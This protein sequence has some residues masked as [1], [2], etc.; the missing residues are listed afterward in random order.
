MLGVS[1]VSLSIFGGLLNPGLDL[2]QG[3]LMGVI[4]PLISLILG[5]CII[6]ILD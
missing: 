4:Q 2:G 6:A 3:S 1:C 5:I